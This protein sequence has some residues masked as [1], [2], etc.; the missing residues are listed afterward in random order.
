MRNRV[1][2]WVS[3]TTWLALVLFAGMMI[4]FSADK[5]NEQESYGKAWATA[6]EQKK[7]MLILLTADWCTP[8]QQLKK[9][10]ATLL[11]KL[12]E[13]YIV[14]YVDIDKEPG[15]KEAY[16]KAGLWYGG[17]PTIYVTQ[18]DEKVQ[19]TIKGQTSGYMTKSEFVKWHNNL[20]P[21]K[22]APLRPKASDHIGPLAPLRIE[23]EQ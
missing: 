5:V 21:K 23:D 19:Q 10:I 2:F 15:V 16:R 3:L 7:P 12:R 20:Y 13:S 17:V 9:E 8:C 18:W 6:Y 22:L 4:A 14:Y 1:N 11:P